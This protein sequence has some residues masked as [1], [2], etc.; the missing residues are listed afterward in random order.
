VTISGG[1]RRLVVAVGVAAG[2]VLVTGPA[3][4]AHANLDTSTPGNGQRIEAAP[5]TITL[6]LTEPVELLRT[7]IELVDDGGRG[8]PLG[9]VTSSPRDGRRINGP[10]VLSVSVT[11][12]LAAGS[13]H[14]SWRTVSTDDMHSTYG[15]FTFGVGTTVDSTGDAAGSRPDDVLRLPGE[16]VLRWLVF[17]GLAGLVGACSLALL[18]GARRV[19]P[20]DTLHRLRAIGWRL[21]AVGVGGALAL[22]GLLLWGSPEAAWTS[23]FG[24]VWAGYLALLVVATILARRAAQAA[25]TGDDD[26]AANP[27]TAA[28]VVVALL[29]AAVSALVG[30]AAAATGVGWVTVATAAHLA[31]AA[32][33]AGGVL[34]LV[35]LGVAA[36]PLL[37]SYAVLAAPAVVVALISGL[38]LAGVLVPSVGAV[39]GSS[40]GSVL[41]VKVVLVG[42]AMVLGG[43]NATS[44]RS[45]T[46]S[47]S[48][49]ATAATAGAGR[50]SGRAL[51]LESA[52]LLLVLGAAGA[53]GSLGPPTSVFWAPTPT[54]V[55]DTEPLTSQVEDLL[56]TVSATPNHPGQNFVAVDVRNTRRPAPGPVTAVDV[57]VGDG[58]AA[59]AVR[60]ADGTWLL[61]TE[62]VRVSGPVNLTVTVSRDGLDD[63]STSIAWTVAAAPGTEQ[64]GAPLSA[65]TSGL[66][67]LVAL[68]AG[69][70]GLLA[71]ARS[72][73]RR[74]PVLA[75]LVGQQS[76]GSPTPSEPSSPSHPGAPAAEIDRP[77]RDGQ[78]ASSRS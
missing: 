3:A 63:V 67:V 54:T 15:S 50:R 72:R 73:R 12:P 6:G 57:A 49:T 14:V 76:S 2:L 36:R 40:Y 33:W 13:Y 35:L 44:A 26:R 46:R 17:T 4:H 7:S 8:I 48:A 61:P 21:G 58:A 69:L 31:A 34:A 66:I 77:D 23:R 25:R 16:T 19:A 37:R 47:R 42:A 71:M 51:S 29:A 20:V 1:L 22:E 59:A 43:L 10:V 64:G 39:T 74:G 60:Q 5:P 24:R 30:H 18:G 11:Q 38:V 45:R 62:A 75:P 32:V 56:V 41:V 27:S 53:L 65:L 70:A 52:V 28:A 9:K 55:A 68:A 78:P